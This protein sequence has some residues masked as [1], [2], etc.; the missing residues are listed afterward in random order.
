MPT[1]AHSTEQNPEALI[2]RLERF[3][4][5]FP[6]LIE[7]FAPEDLTWKPDA[8]SWSVHEIICHMA[9]E[10]VLDFRTRVLSTLTDPSKPWPPIDP[11]GIAITRDYPSLD[12]ATELNRWINDRTQSIS[13]LRTLESPDWS[14]A[15]QH[16]KFGPMIAIDLL[17]AWSAHD[18]LH[19]RQIVKRLHQLASRDAGP[20][21]TT[22]Y[23]GDW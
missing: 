17:A 19:A 23:A 3:L 10:E 22:Q 14:S 1:Q 20:K 4:T 6:A 18:A 12:R 11:V 2:E 8:M 5:T 21:S 15:H 16:P 13:L 7:A 9:D